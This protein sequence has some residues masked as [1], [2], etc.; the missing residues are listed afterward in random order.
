MLCVM[1]AVLAA[2]L[3][4][5]CAQGNSAPKTSPPVQSEKETRT[6]AQRKI[7]S[8]ILFEIYRRRGEAEAKHV[9][10]GPTGVRI[11][12][13][14]RAYVDIRADVSPALEK[15]I[16]DAGGTIVSTSREYRSV[17]AWIPLM[18]LEHIAADASVRAVEPTAEA[19]TR[20]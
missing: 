15:K 7:N 20:K 19:E 10:P 13:K 11:D 6:P 8:Q 2:A 18:R 3:S 5:A 9:P 12:E 4:A 1:T 16:R 17:L 14:D